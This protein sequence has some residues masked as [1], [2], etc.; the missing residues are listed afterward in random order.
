[1]NTLTYSGTEAGKTLSVSPLRITDTAFVVAVPSLPHGARPIIDDQSSTCVGFIHENTKNIWHIFDVSGQCVG[2]K[3]APLETPL[4]DPY[5]LIL[6]G[7]AVVKFIR[8]GFSAVARLATGRT[9]FS[10]TSEITSRIFP[11][12][13]SRLQGLSV[14]Q[15]P[16]QRPS[17]WRISDDLCLSISSNWR[18][19]MESECSTHRRWRVY[20]DMKSRCPVL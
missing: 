16:R 13:R 1:M 6:I 8:A 12:L 19:S 15:L 18:S 20:F 17:T 14:K 10:T 7:P 11:L 4:I 3:E 5:D 2:I 9:A